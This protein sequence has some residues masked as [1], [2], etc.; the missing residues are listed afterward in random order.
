MIQETAVSVEPKR[1]LHRATQPIAN[2]SHCQLGSPIPTR[3]TVS[4][5][6]A[7]CYVGVYLEGCV[8]EKRRS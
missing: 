5:N 7:H 4:I 2:S 6:A 8:A 3:T 1:G